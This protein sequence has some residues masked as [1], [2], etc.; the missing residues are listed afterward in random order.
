MKSKIIPLAAFSAMMTAISTVNAEP[1]SAFGSGFDV[2]GFYR[3]FTLE[4]ITPENQQKWPYYKYVSAN[5]SEFAA[6]GVEK[7]PPAK[8]PAKLVVASKENSFDLNTEYLDGRSFIESM[9]ATQVK[10]FV[11]MK[12]N[13][14][15]AEFYDNGFNVDDTNLLQ[16]ASKT[17]AAIIVHQLIDQGKIKLADKVED[18]IPDFKGS[19]MGKATVQQV[20]D[21]TSGMPQLLDYHTPGALGYLFELEIGLKKGTTRGHLAILKET[22][23]D[24]KPG[25]AWQYSD[26]NTDTLGL[27]AEAASGKKFSGLLANLFDTIGS[28]QGG[29]I[30]K[31]SDGS[32][33]PCYGISMSAR[34]YALFHQW[35][36]EGK[37]PKSYYESATDLEKSICSKNE[38]AA[39]AHPET[40]YGS[41]SYYIADNNVL[42]SNGSFGETGYSDM[43]TGL[44]VVFL[45]DWAVNAEIAKQADNRKR[46]LAIMNAY[47]ASQL[48]ARK[49]GI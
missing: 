10:G 4:E 49:S 14:I 47:I 18:I 39:L 15:F 6:H 19:D 31:T 28:N 43:K 12:D 22:K 41:Q 13:K 33:S 27:L 32:T 44:A 17:F 24:K 29:S 7:L 34:D 40:E 38:L 9:Q 16:S 11:V 21:H 30:A 35:I 45:S 3:P 1:P 46:A 2:Q 37:A 48:K 26:M 25:E 5:W 23:A 42:F 36:A 8:K 20:L